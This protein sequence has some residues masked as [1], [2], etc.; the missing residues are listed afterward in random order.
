MPGAKLQA[1][2]AKGLG[3]TH[4]KLEEEILASRNDRLRE[5]AAEKAR[6][7]EAPPRPAESNDPYQHA[8]REGLE[9]IHRELEKL[10]LL[11]NTNRGR[12]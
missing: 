12:S 7:T 2:L 9:V 1:R 8:V 11:V 10:F 4:A 6:G 5:D 3:V